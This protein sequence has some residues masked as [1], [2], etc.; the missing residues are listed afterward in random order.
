MGTGHWR[1]GPCARAYYSPRGKL[2][3][4]SWVSRSNACLLEDSDMSVCRMEIICDGD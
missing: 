2:H 4:P 1:R 3:D